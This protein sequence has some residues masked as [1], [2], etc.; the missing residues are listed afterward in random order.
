MEDFKDFKLFN[1]DNFSL[2]S[3]SWYAQVAFLG[4]PQ[5]KRISFQNYKHWYLIPIWSANAV[6]GTVV[7]R[8]LHGGSLE[9]THTVLMKTPLHIPR[10]D[11]YAQDNS[12]VPTP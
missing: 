1:C 10:L 3:C 4:K 6:K 7:N 11:A 9:I 5:F 12:L 8:V 2:F